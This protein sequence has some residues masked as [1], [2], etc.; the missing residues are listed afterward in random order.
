MKKESIILGV[1][2]VIVVFLVGTIIVQSGSRQTSTTAGAPAVVD[3]E[4]D[5]VFFTQEVERNPSNR[6]AWVQ[7]GNLYFGARQPVKAIEAYDKALELHRPDPNVLTDQGT[8]FRELG[9]YDR[10]LDNFYEAQQVDPNHHQSLFNMGVVYRYDLNDYPRAF[11][12]WSQY[13]RMWPNSPGADRLRPELD[14][15]RAQMPQ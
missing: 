13:V 14:F 10:A 5:I 6:Q 3:V 7:L 12:V 15:L 4:R 9:W 2:V 11:D 8:M 1:I